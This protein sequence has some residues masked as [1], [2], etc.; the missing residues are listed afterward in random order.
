MRLRTLAAPEESILSLRA[1][2]GEYARYVWRHP[3][4]VAAV[5]AE[6]CY[7]FVRAPWGGGA[8]GDGGAAAPLQGW[9]SPGSD[10]WKEVE[11]WTH[12]RTFAL[13]HFRTFALSHFRTF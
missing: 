4:V 7:R 12:F 8:G 1:I 2:A 13:S 3:S 10:R 9:Q 5:R 6:A 11:R